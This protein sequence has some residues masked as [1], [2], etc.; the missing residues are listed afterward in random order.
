MSKQASE[1]SKNTVF[2][3]LFAGTTTDLKVAPMGDNSKAKKDYRMYAVH[4]SCIRIIDGFNARMDYGDVESLAMS[5]KAEHEATGQALIQPIILKSVK[6]DA[7]AFDLMA[8]HRRMMAAQWLWENLQY[9]VGE[10][11]A[12]IYKYDTPPHVLMG[13]HMRENDQKPLLPI[14]EAINFKRWKDAGYTLESIREI[15]GRSVCHISKRLTLLTGADEVIDAVADGSLQ[16]QTAAE[17]I[18]RRKGDEEAQKELV[19]KAT[20]SKE[21]AKA[22]REQ[23]KAEMN[24]KGRKQRTKKREQGGKPANDKPDVPRL[25]LKEHQELVKSHTAWAA[26]FVKTYGIKC[27]QA[28]VM[29]KA[30][31]F[32]KES[33]AGYRKMVNMLQE[34]G[35][36]DGVAL[37]LGIEL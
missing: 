31:E 6:G 36:I 21:G 20:E 2:A 8:G 3:E 17:I 15:S 23:L 32:R 37:V 35:K 11:Q 26:D 34:F 28:E 22:V 30:A 27:E 10:L 13:A 14:E 12:K 4:P 24:S 7:K 29:K 9:D 5:M 25:S 33:D 18:V 1:L 19:Q 16:S